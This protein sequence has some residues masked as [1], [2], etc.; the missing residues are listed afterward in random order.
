MDWNA[1]GFRLPTEAE[2]ENVSRSGLEG[3][4]FPW[5]D[6]TYGIGVNYG[7]NPGEAIE[8][9]QFDPTNYGPL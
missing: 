9:G 6:G 7:H 4:L 3:S 2:W 8:V 1:N 5:G